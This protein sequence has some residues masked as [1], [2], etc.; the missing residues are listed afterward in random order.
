M[1]LAF[2]T[3]LLKDGANSVGGGI[4]INYKGFVEAGL[5]KDG[6]S[7]DSVDEGVERG[8]M[9]I[10]PMESASLHAMGDEGVKWGSKHTEIANVHAIKVEEAEKGMQFA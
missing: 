5:S 7:A 9:F 6:S 3:P 4:A 1:E 10:I 2:L 8:F